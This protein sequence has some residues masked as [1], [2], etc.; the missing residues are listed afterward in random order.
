MAA[1]QAFCS[2]HPQKGVLIVIYLNAAKRIE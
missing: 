1:K 2:E